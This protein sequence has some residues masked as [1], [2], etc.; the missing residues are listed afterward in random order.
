MVRPRHWAHRARCIHGIFGKNGRGAGDRDV[1]VL[2]LSG[3][4]TLAT[5]RYLWLPYV[6]Y[7]LLW[8]PRRRQH[9]FRHV[10]ICIL[11]GMYCRD[12]ATY[13][14]TNS[15]RRCWESQRVLLTCG[16][17]CLCLLRRT[18]GCVRRNAQIYAGRALLHGTDRLFW[19]WLELAT[20]KYS[21]HRHNTLSSKLG[22]K[23]L[24]VESG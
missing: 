24:S 20:P 10:L 14:F 7:S 11:S 12:G 8:W 13:N 23:Q 2:V 6:V 22:G 17:A 15:Q 5:G 19:G 16:C 3:P 21:I 4:V 9:N 18:A 1:W